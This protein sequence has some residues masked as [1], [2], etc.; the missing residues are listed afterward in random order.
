MLASLKQGLED[1]QEGRH[2]EA[3]SIFLVGLILVVLGITGVASQKVISSAL[4]L[5]VTFLVFQTARARSLGQTALDHVLQGREA[6]KPFTELVR[7][8]KDL[9]VYGPSAI[10]ISIHAADIRQQILERGGEVR[11]LVLNP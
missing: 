8:A 3:Y 7:D 11:I 6:F 4:L 2:R 5:A 10:N 1:I 9:Y